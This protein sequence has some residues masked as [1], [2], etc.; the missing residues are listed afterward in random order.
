MLAS[1]RSDFYLLKSY[2]KTIWGVFLLLMVFA[3]IQQSAYMAYFYP[4]FMSIFLPLS[5][6]SLSEQSGWEAMLLSAPV[7]RSGIV[8]GRYLLC[9]AI[10]GI[11]VLF[12]FVGALA[13]ERG[14]LDTPLHGLFIALSFEL[15]LGAIVLPVVYRFGPTRARFVIM[16]ICIIPAL[17]T[18]LL[19]QGLENNQAEVERLLARLTELP[20]LLLFLVLCAALYAVSMAISSAIYRR[21]EF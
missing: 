11:T 19:M 5:L 16:A 10:G 18:P 21:K 9:A 13:A 14:A 20:C 1:F 17:V 3:V 15:L 6:F 4:V 7:T 12:G 8:R 2:L